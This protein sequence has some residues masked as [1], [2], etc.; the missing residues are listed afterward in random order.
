[1]SYAGINPYPFVPYNFND[2]QQ[3][4]NNY[5]EYMLNRTQSIFRYE[6]LPKTIPARNLELMLQTN[7][8]VAIAEVKGDLYAFTGGLGG[9]PNVYYMPTIYTIANPALNYSANLKIDP[10]SQDLDQQEAIVIPND[11]LYKGLLPM[12]RKYATL[13]TEIDISIRLST[14]NT[15][16]TSLI[17]A[18]DDRTERSAEKYLEQLEDGD[19]A[20][21]GETAFLDGV[22]VQ[23]YSDTSTGTNILQLIELKNTTM[24]QW[25]NDLGL[26]SNI[27]NKREY[28]SDAQTMD[29][30]DSL[31]PLI[32][33]ML[34][35]RLR[36]IKKINE[37]WGLNIECEL[38]SAWEDN[39]QQVMQA[40]GEV[41]YP[42][43][44][45]QAAEDVIGEKAEEEEETAQEVINENEQQPSE[46][47]SEEIK[48]EVEEEQEDNSSSSSS[49]SEENE[50]E[51]ENDEEKGK[52]EEDE[53]KKEK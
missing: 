11:S 28:V 45:A 13:L 41:P 48:E 10:T 9:E 14:I 33:D 5:I 50:N 18:Q 6:G 25:L 21:V 24:A 31:L 19:L 15:R 46:T 51:N 7:G 27:N 17:S 39:Q 35:C 30:S 26:D 29:E 32:D 1:M 53:S 2:K 47:R 52:E 22:K 34:R 44:D 38:N 12:D 23:P 49:S 43:Q 16:A 3:C 42:V 36:A 4:I 20:I 40:N 8:N 37:K